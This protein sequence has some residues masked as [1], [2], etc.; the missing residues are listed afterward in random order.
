MSWQR[1]VWLL[2]LAN[3][4]VSCGFTLVIPF[5]AMF[6]AEL[7]IN[8]TTA[9]ARW[10]GYVFSATFVSAAIMAPVYGALADWMG[11]RRIL[12]FSSLGMAS[13]VWTMGN[14]SSVYHLFLMRFIQG[15]FAGFIPIAIA[16]IA[17]QTPKQHVGKALGQVQSGATTGSI[18]GPFIGG[19]IIEWFD[20][21]H[22]FYATSAMLL[23]A[24]VLALLVNEEK[25]QLN[26]PAAVKGRSRSLSMKEMVIQHRPVLALLA[27][28]FMIQVASLSVEPIVSLLVNQQHVSHAS[29]WAGLVIA[30]LGFGSALSAPVLGKIGDQAGHRKVLLLSLIGA[31]LMFFPQSVE[32]QPWELTLNR[33]LL[34]LFVGGLL[35]S[36]NALIREQTVREWQNRIY[37]LNTS[38]MFVGNLL[39]PLLGG[40]VVSLWGLSGVFVSTGLLLLLNALWV[41]YQ[42]P[43]ANNRKRM[44]RHA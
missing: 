25:E 38:A 42:V 4:F 30:A 28:T 19:L 27:V 12:I 37:G 8:E 16:L 26:E 13:V 18:I 34:G 23:L 3:F 36:V 17:T 10:A 6:I 29:V 20:F 11:R 35:P 31:A 21:R 39:G 44:E 33:F 1:N 24:C 15:F 9:N 41:F 5:L 14:S 7:G 2:W 40:S 32:S 43:S 22:A